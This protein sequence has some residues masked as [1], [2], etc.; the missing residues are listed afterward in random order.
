MPFGT[1]NAVTRHL[2]YAVYRWSRTDGR[3]AIRYGPPT[4]FRYRPDWQRFGFS[5]WTSLGCHP[6]KIFMVGSGA[7]V[8]HHPAEVGGRWKGRFGPAP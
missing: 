5:L 2:E 7:P 8:L 6:S 3:R 1:P 4:R